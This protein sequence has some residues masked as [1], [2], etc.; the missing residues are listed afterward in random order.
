MKEY[1]I[2]HVSE[3]ELMVVQMDYFYT[4][5]IKLSNNSLKRLKLM[6]LEFYDIL[7]DCSSEKFKELFPYRC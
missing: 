5:N 3:H 6:D 2:S 7:R 1:D 4:I